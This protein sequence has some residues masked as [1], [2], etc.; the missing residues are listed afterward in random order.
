MIANSAIIYPCVKLGMNVI[1][2]DLCIIGAYFKG[3]FQEET[4]IGDNAL[5]RAGTI[6]YGGSRIGKNFQTGNKTNIREFNVIRDDV[7][8][9]TLAV[10]EHHV[11][12]GN[13]VRIHS[14]AFIPEYTVLEDGCWIGPNVVLTNSKY[15]RS[16]N[17]K[18]SLLGVRVMKNAII[19]ANSTLLPG[20]KI[21]EFAFVGA[22]SVVTKDVMSKTVVAGNPARVI[23]NISELPYNLS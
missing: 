23:K 2:E 12:I 9:G 4:I 21:G 18:E 6:I 5:I 7:S 3:Y 19:G 16:I 1:I 15:P 20:I 11:E 10:I 22:G 17:S 14:Q 13:G 8:I